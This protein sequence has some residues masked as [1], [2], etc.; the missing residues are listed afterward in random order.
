MK[1]NFDHPINRRGTS[2]V[3]W[4]V[5]DRDFQ[6][7]D[8]LPMWIADMDFA[9][10][11]AITEEMHKRVE[12]GV[13][14]YS[15]LPDAYYDAVIRWMRRRHGCEV[16]K[17]W[18]SYT[19][20]VVTALNYAVQA[21]T[22][23]GDEI[24]VHTP[25]YHPFFSVIEEQGR[26][27]V[28]SPLKEEDLHYTMDFEDMER[29]IS[30]K[31]KAVLFCSPH[32]PVGRVWTS[33]ELEQLA[34]FCKRHD[35]YL[36]CDEIHNDLVFKKHTMILTV[37]EA[38]AQRTILCT[39]P[40]KTFNIA[41]VQ[42]SNTII[43]NEDIRKKFQDLLNKAHIASAHAMAAPALIGA[44]DGSEDWLEELLVY[45]E[46]NMDLFCETIARELPMLRVR[47]PEGT[48]LTWVDCSGLGLTAEELKRFM[49]D[50]CGLALSS[51]I[52]F[53]EE[54]A[55]FMRV[56]LACPRS[57]VEE[58]LRRLKKGCLSK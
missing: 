23:P 50:R 18:I 15:M 54:G 22:E 6:G 3:K 5:A 38:L 25:V 11:P 16:Q 51:G 30:E 46:G 34:D 40:S 52:V 36:I 19:A 37:D 47:K 49:V 17:E 33:G 56:N 41:G 10:A 29:R 4:D 12:E 26:V 21:I 44:Y 9:T 24:M 31:T 2:C 32:N 42:V 55:Q 7:A 58:C 20:G 53:G 35:L 45:L 8:L 48:Y 13:F 27:L 14:G 1:F 57:Y 39:A 43:P 28:R